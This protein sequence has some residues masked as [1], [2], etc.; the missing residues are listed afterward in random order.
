MTETKTP[1]EVLYSEYLTLTDGGRLTVSQRLSFIKK[2]I[3]FVSDRL[4]LDDSDV[5]DDLHQKISWYIQNTRPF[6]DFLGIVTN[7]N[8]GYLPGDDDDEQV[9]ETRDVLYLNFFIHRLLLQYG[10]DSLHQD[11]LQELIIVYPKLNSDWKSTFD[12]VLNTPCMLNNLKLSVSDTDYPE[13]R[14][15]QVIQLFLTPKLY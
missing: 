6:S 12:S 7:V 14:D 4:E 1:L 15:E 11:I 13:F 9:L 3:V 2:V 10:N 8:S 5:N